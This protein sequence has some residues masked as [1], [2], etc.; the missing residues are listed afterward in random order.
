MVGVAQLFKMSAE[1]KYI[2]NYVEGIE[3]KV[4]TMLNEHGKPHVQ[5]SSLNL[6]ELAKFRHD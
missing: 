5:S 2:D 4:D 6:N 3:A 1:T